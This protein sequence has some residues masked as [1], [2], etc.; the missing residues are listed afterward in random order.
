[1]AWRG[2]KNFGARIR[3]KLADRLDAVAPWQIDRAARWRDLGREIDFLL[4]V[5]ADSTAKY[6]NPVPTE[7]VT[8]SRKY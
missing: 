7:A 1:L 6:A 2:F 5:A 3:P 4:V 8:R